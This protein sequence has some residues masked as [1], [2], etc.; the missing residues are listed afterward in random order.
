MTRV[1]CPQDQCVFW[2]EGVCGAD[3]IALDPEQLSCVTMEDIK[4]LILQGE[5]LDEWGEEIEE[6]EEDEDDEEWEDERLFDD[7]DDEDD[8]WEPY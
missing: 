4:D 5:D 3:E 2:D 6:I 8:D 7:D 1:L